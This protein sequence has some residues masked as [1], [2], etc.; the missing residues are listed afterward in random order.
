MERTDRY[1]AKAFFALPCIAGSTVSFLLVAAYFWSIV[2]TVR[3]E[4]RVR[5]PVPLIICCGAF[6]FYFLVTSVSA[7]ARGLDWPAWKIVFETL[8]FVLIAFVALRIRTTPGANLIDPIVLGSA[9][10]AML[11]AVV[12]LAEGYLL[13]TSRAEGG[14]GN[15][16]IFAV[17][18]LLLS[19]LSLTGLLREGQ[20]SPLLPILGFVG[21]MIALKASGSRLLVAYV[22]VLGLIFLY[23][24]GRICRP[25]RRTWAIIAAAALLGLIMAAFLFDRQLTSIL[26]ELSTLNNQVDSSSGKRLLMYKA[27]LAAFLQQ[28]FLGYGPQNLMAAIHPYLPPE[29]A[30][31]IHFSHLHN[32][33]LDHAIG[34]GLFGVAA[35]LLVF[36]CPLWCAFRME[37][38]RETE[39]LRYMLTIVLAV[40]FLNGLTNITFSHDIILAVYLYSVTAILCSGRYE[41]SE[42]GLPERNRAVTALPETP[43]TA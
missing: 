9:V 16:G 27:A 37:P 43:P 30:D 19:F 31:L 20:R 11:G 4:L 5:L 33:F 8:P 40:F 1:F 15:S 2:R 38:S 18:A 12:G 22:P 42:T 26:R 28:P 7:L 32:I 21:G 23:A 14:A 35:F 39:I 29:S 25:S 13:Q 6:C 36:I 41:G 24:Y 17:I 34:S 10:G 3:G